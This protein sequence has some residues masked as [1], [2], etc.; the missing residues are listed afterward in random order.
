MD[1]AGVRAGRLL[2]RRRPVRRRRVPRER[3]T[4]MSM[5]AGKSVL[6][7]GAAGGLGRAETLLLA[8]LGAKLV[9]CD[10]GRDVE[11]VGADPGAVEAIAADARALGAEVVTSAEDAAA[12]GAADRLV[13]L[14]AS[15]YGRLDGVVYSAGIRRDRSLAKTTADD[16]DRM[17]DVHVRGSFHVARAAAAAMIDAG[18]G[19]SIVLSTG[20]VGFFG[21]AR[22]T[23][24]ALCAG[25]IAGFVRSAAIE[26]RRHGVRVNAVAPTA[27]TRLTEDSALFRG[28][29]A[30][31]MT[32][33]HVAPVVAFLLSDAAKDVH[34]DVLG[35]AGGR[36]YALQSRETTGAFAEGRAFDPGEIG[37]VYAE[38][39]RTGA[40]GS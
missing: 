14:A 30:T 17:L 7:V 22:K 1:T 34:G 2:Q 6:V 38:V 23:S 28:I 18:T 35:V 11:G 40:S 15:T 4:K 27:R 20:P 10:A 3:L 12:A 32:P 36:I 33:E 5:L 21:V 37:G 9:L 24:E 26:L 16:L 39:T 19:G 13:A 8:R 29:A 25:A 31:S